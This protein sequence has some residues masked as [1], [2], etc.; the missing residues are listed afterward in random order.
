MLIFER[1]LLKPVIL[2][3][4]QKTAVVIDAG[5]EPVKLLGIIRLSNTLKFA[6][7]GV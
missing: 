7:V 4:F 2:P 6:K 1:V 3:S 5:C